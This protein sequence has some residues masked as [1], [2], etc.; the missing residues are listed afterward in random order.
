M[1]ACMQASASSKS[2]S[3]KTTPVS[4]SSPRTPGTADLSQAS[5]DESSQ[6]GAPTPVRE[7]PEGVFNTGKHKHHSW[8]WLKRECFC[9]FDEC[10]RSCRRIHYIL[11]MTDLTASPRPLLGRLSQN[12]V[13]LNTSFYVLSYICVYVM[14][15]WS[16][17]QD[18]GCSEAQARPP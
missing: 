3:K 8:E 14:S 10:L 17:S 12:L 18:H 11:T 15:C 13:M 5:Q 2:A 6:Q 1:C 9:A 16:S 4:Q 7:L